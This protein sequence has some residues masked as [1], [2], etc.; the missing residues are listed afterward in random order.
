MRYAH[1]YLVALST[2]I[3]MIAAGCS[4][5]VAESSETQSSTRGDRASAAGNATLP[6]SSPLVISPFRTGE[7]V[8]VHLRRDALGFT[9]NSA[10][11]IEQSGAYAQP[12]RVVGMIESSSAD[13]INIR[14]DDNTRV[15]IPMQMVLA[16]IM[17]P[18]TAAVE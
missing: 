7:R 16:V 3:A 6:P 14:R 1:L 4:F 8:E 10:V 17:E 12:L 5:T 15:A 13:W 11:G 2:A 9:G 18:A